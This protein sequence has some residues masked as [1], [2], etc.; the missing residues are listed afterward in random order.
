M[1][2]TLLALILAASAA[3]SQ[4]AVNNA[5]LDLEGPRLGLTYLNPGLI[6]RLAKDRDVDLK[7]VVIQFGWQ[8]E[9]RFFTLN[10]G[11]T[12]VSELILL[13]G[14]F[15]QG[16]FLPSATWLLGM[17]SGRGAEFGLGPNL[18]LAGSAIVFAA[19]VTH[20]TEGVNFP[21]NLALAYSEKGARIS[22]LFGFN[23][24][25]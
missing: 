1:A 18:S 24:R 20:Q 12:G 3:W 23:T 7:P 5:P 15:E 8:N 22:L 17:R 9:S 6:D 11:T 13:L 21:V 25:S 10:S 2:R 19:G 4:P 14:G 16:L